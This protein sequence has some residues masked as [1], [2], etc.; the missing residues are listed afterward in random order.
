AT[1]MTIGELNTYYQNKYQETPDLDD[2]LQI[3]EEAG[4]ILLLESNQTVDTQTVKTLFNDNTSAQ[5]QAQQFHFTQFPESLA[6][7]LYSKFTLYLSLIII[8]IAC[9]A[10]ILDPSIVPGWQ[11]LVFTEHITLLNFSLM[12]IG[13]IGVCFHE[14]AHLV[15]ARSFGIGTHLGIGHRMWILVAEADMTGVWILPHKKRYVPFLAGPLLDLTITSLLFILLFAVS[16]GW[17]ALP[18]TVLLIIRAV[19]FVYLLGLLWQ[20]Y[21]FLRTDFYYVI[22]NYFRCK[23]LMGDAI[24]LLQNTFAKVFPWLRSSDQSHI[25]PKERQ[26]IQIYAWFWVIG[27]I[28]VL[29]VFVFVV[30][31]LLYNYILIIGQILLAGYQANPYAFIDALLIGTIVIGFQGFGIVLWIRSIYQ[32]WRQTYVQT[33]QTSNIPSLGESNHSGS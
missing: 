6:Q 12:V 11:S 30:V 18:Y 5:K 10:I 27:R 3:L 16:S 2:F 23:N 33:S 13:F 28:I 4:F 26:A 7:R 17:I 24:N 21:F 14:M 25:P 8:S 20:C 1:G 29:L 9:I 31:P 32:S 15:A 19:I 22:A